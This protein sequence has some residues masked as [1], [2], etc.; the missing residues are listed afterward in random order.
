MEYLF[1][2]LLLLYYVYKHDIKN[3]ERNAIKHQRIIIVLLILLAGFRYRMAPDS[4][5]FEYEFNN[6][7]PSIYKLTLSSITDLR[8]PFG[9]VFI[10]SFFFTFTNYIIFQIACA[11]ISN[12]LVLSFIRSVSNK[13]FTVLLFYYVY[14]FCYLN[15]D[16]MREFMA[17]SFELFALSKLIEGNKKKALLL[18]IIGPLIHSFSFFFYIII[19]IA[20]FESGKKII[21][22]GC[23]LT[24]FVMA[25]F[26]NIIALMTAYFPGMSLSFIYYALADVDHI[27]IVGYMTKILVPI[28]LYC[29]LSQ[30][31]KK[32]FSII[33]NTKYPNSNDLYNEHN[34]LIGILIL[35]F[36][37]FVLLRWSIPY[38]ERMFNYFVII[39]YV[40]FAFGFYNFLKSYDKPRLTFIKLLIVIL[41]CLIPHFKEMTT[42]MDS[43]VPY[44]NRYIPYNSF[45]EKKYIQERELIIS[46]EQR[47]YD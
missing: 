1:I 36:L 14:S 7:Y 2:F 44:Y 32:K 28:M 45:F 24:I 23:F 17:V 9:W 11:A 43:G 20:Y 25:Y 19:I 10:N 8:Y 26:Q 29:V 13:V 16:V 37:I 31:N 41:I 33:Q 4:V 35:A 18:G 22:I 46:N 38:I 21:L 30:S 15:M 39:N 40:I 27:S 5:T 34:H 47:V 12:L 42:I 6:I 3:N